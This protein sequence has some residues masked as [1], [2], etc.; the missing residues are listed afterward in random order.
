M[1]ESVPAPKSTSGSSG[2]LGSTSDQLITTPSDSGAQIVW[3]CSTVSS[4]AQS[5]SGLMMTES[6]SFAAT[7]SV[8]SIPLASHSVASSSLIGREALEMSV[9]P[10][11]NDLKPPPVPEVATVTL[12]SG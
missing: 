10:A 5:F 1:P 12:T 11:Q 7:I 3:S 2:K 9:S 8:Y 6:P 4:V